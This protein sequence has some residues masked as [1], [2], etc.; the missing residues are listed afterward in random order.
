VVPPTVTGS[1]ARNS[2]LRAMLP[3]VEPC[4]RA[5]PITNVLD[6]LGIDLGA[7]DRL[8]DGMAEQGRP[9]GGC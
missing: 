4:C 8:T 9:F 3:P 5:A 2:A 7:R 1:P 6:L